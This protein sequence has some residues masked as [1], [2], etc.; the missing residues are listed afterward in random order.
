MGSS[1]RRPWLPE[2][3]ELG[4]VDVG[5]A[6]PS[7]VVAL[8]PAGLH[9]S[10]HGESADHELPGGCRRRHQLQHA[11]QSSPLARRNLT[12][13]RPSADRCSA[14]KRHSSSLIASR[15]TPKISEFKALTRAFRAV[16]DASD[17]AATRVL[18]TRSRRRREEASMPSRT[19]RH[20][21]SARMQAEHQRLAR[22]IHEAI[23]QDL[24]PLERKVADLELRRQGGLA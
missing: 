22:L 16:Q 18:A 12:D 9:P 8:D 17:G 5:P 15:P 14:A 10:A 7:L 19:R 4:Q 23:R 24:R 20:T 3:P 21:T 11:W 13:L 2:A 1:V 6:I